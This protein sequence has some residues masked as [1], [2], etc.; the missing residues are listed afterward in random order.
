MRWPTSGMAFGRHQKTPINLC[1]GYAG[2][3]IQAVGMI[4]LIITNIKHHK[5]KI[6]Q[7]KMNTIRRT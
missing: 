3:I 5:V 7:Y 1:G 6:M 4:L 2:A